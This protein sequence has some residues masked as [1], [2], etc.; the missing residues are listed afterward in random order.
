MFLLHAEEIYMINYEKLEDL[1]H[2][3]LESK[4]KSRRTLLAGEHR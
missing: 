1:L 3:V 4:A 2:G